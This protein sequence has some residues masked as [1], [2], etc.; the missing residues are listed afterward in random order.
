M[1]RWTRPLG[2]IILVTIIHLVGSTISIPNPVAS[3]H[4]GTSLSS[5]QPAY[6]Q[7]N[8]R[9]AIASAVY[10]QLPD[11]PLENQYVHTETGDV[12]LNNTLVYRLLQYHSTVQYRPLRSRFDWKL[13]LADYMGA[14]EWMDEERYPDRFL[15]SNPFH[16]DIEVMRTLNRQQ[17]EDLIQALLMVLDP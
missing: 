5:V 16:Q 3:D 11:F 10:D 1:K 13:T 8:D 15:Q 17:R 14:N 7:A 6:A 2:L 4:P 12:V 9:R